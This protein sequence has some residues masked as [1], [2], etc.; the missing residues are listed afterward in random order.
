M[1][2]FMG[3]RSI[4]Y[5]TESDIQKLSELNKQLSAISNRKNIEP[6]L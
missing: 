4:S 6:M 3:R 2:E 1:E 5:L